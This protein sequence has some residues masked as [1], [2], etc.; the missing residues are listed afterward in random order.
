LTLKERLKNSI[1]WIAG[2]VAIAAFAVGYSKRQLQFIDRWAR[3]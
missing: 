3:R 1:V 2:G